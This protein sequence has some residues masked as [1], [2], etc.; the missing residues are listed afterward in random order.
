LTRARLIACAL[1]CALVAAFAGCHRR[2]KLVDERLL[3]G[4]E[5]ARAWQHRADTHLADHDQAG[6][7]ADVE[8]VLK[9]ELLRGSPEGEEAR[10]DAW[11]RLARLKLGS[12]AAEQE[13]ALADVEHGRAE[14]TRDSFYRAHLETVAGEILEARA[15]RLAAGDA[16]AAKAARRDALDAYARSI[17]IN[18]RVQARLLEETP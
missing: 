15:N 8:Q 16:D 13:R 18:K 7:L 17:A 12:S 2:G 1:A 14:A 10:L 9:I 5:E 3:L 11:A 6:A 4:L